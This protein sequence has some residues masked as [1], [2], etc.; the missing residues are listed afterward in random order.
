MAETLLI[1]I[2][3]EELPPKALRHLGKEF[4]EAVVNGLQS[5]ELVSPSPVYEWFATPR[6]LAVSVSNVQDKSPDKPSKIKVLPVTVALDAQGNATPALAK[7]LNAIGFP[8]ITVSDLI[9][10]QDGKTESFFYEFIAPGISLDGCLG[11][12][13][14]SAITTMRIPK[15]MRYQNKEG[16]DISFVRPAHGLVALHG[17]NVIPVSLLGLN[18]N[19]ITHGHRFQG[20]RDIVLEHATQY[21]AK[22]KTEGAV[23][24][25]FEKRMEI[26]REQ[27]LT[28]ARSLNADLRLEEKEDLIAEVTALVENPAIYMGE[29]ETDYLEVPQECLILTMQQNQKYFPL[30]DSNGKLLSKFLMVSNMRVDD[31]YHIVEGN[32]RVIRPRLADARFFYEQDKKLRLADRISQLANVVF[33]NKLGSQL[34]RIAC[35]Q[36]LA[37]SIAEKM[38]VDVAAA[39]RAALLCKS[40]LVTNMVGEFPELQGTMGRYYAIH[41]GESAEVAEAIETHYYPRF[42]GDSLPSGGVATALALADK[43]YSLAGIFGIGQ[44]PT[45]DK[46]PFALRRAAL[47]LLRMLIEQRLTLNLHELVQMAFSTLNNIENF[48]K[49][50]VELT[51]FLYERLKGFLRDQGYSVLEVESVLADQPGIL[52]DVPAQ[53]AAVRAFMT[54]P[55]AE[56]LAAANKRVAN[57]LKKTAE[58]GEALAKMD[59]S[60][61]KE[62]AEKELHA[63]LHAI[64]PTTTA[65]FESGDYTNY[66]K[67]FAA[68]KTPVD[69]FFDSVMVMVDDKSLRQNRLALLADLR[70][71]M[72]RV[73]DLSK[74]AA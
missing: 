46:D 47:G 7:K 10:A 51:D 18:A 15:V 5:K 12:I 26:I 63:S 43:L 30:F 72:N 68:L 54:L 4:A 23:I 66:L 55:E 49:A 6:R 59:V 69:N 70:K 11:D 27:L 32:Q 34:D 29:F 64:L 31:P 1:E 58:S 74:L 65:L 39:D 40:D 19:R 37:S 3:T 25:S 45:G 28:Q 61:L 50:D 41:D 2:F 53:L 9:R 16:E 8:N 71:A 22:L 35:L 56:S 60:E 33:H 48:K 38:N 52:K 36:R 17:S 24:A 20:K 21:E 57:I 73:A 44:I 13:L 67:S 14:K 62:A 42:A